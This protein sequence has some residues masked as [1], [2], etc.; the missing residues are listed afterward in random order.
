M[1]LKIKEV[2]GKKDLHRFIHLP[3]QIHQGHQNWVPPL[4]VDDWQYFNPEKNKSFSYCDTILL[5]AYRG[6]QVAGRI[7]GIINHRYNE[8]HHENDARFCWPEC[9]NEPDVA[10][11]LLNKVEEWAR[12]KG[13]EKIVGPLGFSDKD[14]QGF[15]VEG[16]DEPVAIATN[17]N[18]PYMIDLIQ[19]NNYVKKIDL[20]VYKINLPD[21]IPEIYEKISTRSLN[22]HQLTVLEFEKKS[23][24]KPM[25]RPVLSLVNETFMDIYG[26]D[27]M[28]GKEMDDLAARYMPI[29]DPRFVK[30]ILNNKN[31]LV[32]FILGMPDM[33][34]GII[35]SRGYLFPFGIIHILRSAKKTKQ[36]NLMLGAIRKDF[37]NIGLDAVMAIKMFGS[38]KK[39]GFEIVDS[40]LEMEDNYKVR[41][42]M[43]RFGGIVYKKYRIYQKNL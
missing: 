3:E 25:I 39:A 22:N 43:E 8:S 33:S 17:C 37:R 29:L 19:A 24:M 40:H 7:M 14:P 38:A 30:C 1:I 20:V 9:R 5:L 21:K 34:K 16:F 10:E 31:E 42:E 13:M 32:A 41:A 2:E 4:Y 15:L 26:F 18:W 12:S 36:L 11:A 23:Q 6:D 28:S 27:P 35:R